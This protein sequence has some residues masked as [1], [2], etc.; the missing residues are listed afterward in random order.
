M[1]KFICRCMAVILLALIGWGA[2]GLLVEPY[3]P[4]DPIETSTQSMD[5]ILTDITYDKYDNIIQKTVFDKAT[6][7]TFIYTFTYEIGWGTS[8]TSSAVKVINSKG[9]LIEWN[10]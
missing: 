3:N 6:G 8:C 5:N 2:I 4:S 10:T 9:E 1:G 7:N